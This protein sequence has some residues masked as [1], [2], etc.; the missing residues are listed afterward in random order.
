MLMGVVARS[1]EGYVS[2]K[3]T[4]R[5][6]MYSLEP[7]LIMSAN[8]KEGQRGRRIETI[9]VG[10]ANHPCVRS[11][12]S[13]EC[14]GGG[15]KQFPLKRRVSDNQASQLVAQLSVAANNEEKIGS[16]YPRCKWPKER[17]L[18]VV[19]NALLC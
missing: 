5:I 14:R 17:G 6:E 16:D 9:R 12:G 7:P 8:I 13:D 10:S 18:L 11:S 19:L 4:V 1:R 2:H 3:R 15:W